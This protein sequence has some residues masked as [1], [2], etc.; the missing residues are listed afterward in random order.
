MKMR[1][2]I[3][4]ACIGAFGIALVSCGRPNSNAENYGTPSSPEQAE[5]VEQSDL[6]GSD[7]SVTFS[8]GTEAAPVS[9]EAMEE[10][11]EESD[12]VVQ[13]SQASAQQ[14]PMLGEKLIAQSD[15]LA[16]H[17]LH[18]KIIGPAY[19]KVALKYQPT[20]ENIAYLVQ[21]I[22]EGGTGVWGTLPMTPHPTLS[23]EDAT[24][25]VKYI[26]TVKAE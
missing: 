10:D 7:G 18:E 5:V 1:V 9:E 26:L 22:K 3:F 2:V 21:K 24:A 23:D 13:E 20:E 11:A 17:K 19:D 14:D 25:M 8:G 15:C 6:V 4:L 12:P 16:C